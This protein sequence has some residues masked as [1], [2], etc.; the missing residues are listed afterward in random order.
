MRQEVRSSLIPGSQQLNKQLDIL[1]EAT[2]V[3]VDC[4]DVGVQAG[5]LGLAEFGWL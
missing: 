2:Y 4:C 5:E 1:I 3:T